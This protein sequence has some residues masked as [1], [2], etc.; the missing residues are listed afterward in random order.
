M[1]GC[2]YILDGLI[3]GGIIVTEQERKEIVTEV[4]FNIKV[5]MDERWVNDFCSMLHWMESC[6]KLGHS[7][8]VAFYSDGDGDFRPSFNIDIEYEKTNGYWKELDGQLP[9][10]EVIFDAG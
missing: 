3:D 7:S 4:E 8:V 9:A 6:G 2:L 10:P 1:D 5:T